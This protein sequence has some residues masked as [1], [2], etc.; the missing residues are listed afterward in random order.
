MT[1]DESGIRFEFDAS[2]DTV[3]H[4][5]TPGDGNNVWPGVDFR[6]P[7]TSGELWLE[8]KSWSARGKHNPS[9][10]LEMNFA[11]SK[12]IEAGL[13]HDELVCKFLGTTAFLYWNGQALPLR[14]DYLVLLHPPSRSSSPLMGP[15]NDKMRSTFGKA[16]SRWPGRIG[17]RVVTLDGFRIRY[18]QFPVTQI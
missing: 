9:E 1:V 2:P 3:K 14:V 13:L 17:Q 16:R 4:D 11:W 18:P 8:V 7:L 15:L 5:D 6:V 10:R 12:K